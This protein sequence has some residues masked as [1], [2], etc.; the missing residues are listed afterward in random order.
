MTI[1]I[2]VFPGSNCD[3]DVQWAAEGCLGIPTRFLW[4]EQRD[5]SGLEAVVLPGG[6][7]YGDYLRCGAIARFAPLLQE[8]VAFA[9]RGGPVLGIC[10]GFQ[11]LTELGLLPGALTRN[12]RLHFLCEPATLNVQPGPCRWLQGYAAGETIHLPIAHGEGRYQLEAGSLAELEEKGQVVLRYQRN[13]NGSI[14]NVAGLCNPAGNVLGLMPHPERACDPLL[15]GID[16]QRLL[17][18]LLG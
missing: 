4:H 17:A 3:R 16:G 10:N 13:P 14:G 2:A 11:V 18:S 7:S 12:R 9:A 5:L 15:G 8:V 1:G 6:F